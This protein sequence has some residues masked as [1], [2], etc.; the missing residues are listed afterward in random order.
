MFKR[1]VLAAILLN[2]TAMAQPKINISKDYLNPR[3]FTAALHGGAWSVEVD[4]VAKNGVLYLADS[5]AHIDTEKTLQKL[6]IETASRLGQRKRSQMFHL[7][8]NIKDDFEQVYP[9]LNKMVKPYV[10]SLNYKMQL[11]L[12]GNI[13]APINWAKYPGYFLFEGDLDAAYDKKSLEKVLML[14]A[15]YKQLAQ[16]IEASQLQAKLEDAVKKSS[17]LGKPLRV[18]NVGDNEESWEE[19]RTSGVD[20][21][22]TERLADLVKFLNL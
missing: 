2:T 11:V 5:H 10:Q 12:A 3:P 4:V 1:I 7:L 6:Y 20:V 19:L 9:I 15:D 16:G 8:I 22:N 14:R 18:I 13:P 17:G 21:L